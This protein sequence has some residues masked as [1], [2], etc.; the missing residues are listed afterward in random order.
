[1]IRDSILKI[2][3][4][5]SPGRLLAGFYFLQK[6]HLSKSGWK[7]SVVKRLP[8]DGH[9]KQLPWFTYACIYFLGPKLKKDHSVFEYGSGNSTIWFA[10]KTQKVVSVEH[11]RE[12]HAHMKGRYVEY[13]HITYLLKDIAS[14]SYQ[15]EI[16][17]YKKVFDIIILDGRERVEC[18][19]NSLNALKDD[20]ILIWDNSD[21][22]KYAKGYQFLM[23]NGFKRLDFYGMGP[24]SAHS[25]CTSIFYRQNNCLDI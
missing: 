6:N 7:K 23:E 20:G 9:Q 15:R 11:D 3:Q 1:M 8:I 2:V 18:A 10:D 13:P 21:R 12:W 4:S 17:N 22:T 16:L 14:G 24:I 5:T 25:W 19:M